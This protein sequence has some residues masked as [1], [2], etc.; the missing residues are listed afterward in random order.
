MSDDFSEKQCPPEDCVPAEPD[1][2]YANIMDH[3]GRPAGGYVHDVGLYITWQNGPLAVDGERKRPNGAFVET[4]IKAAKQRLEFYQRSP[5]A[6][7]ENASAIG[8]LNHAVA[9]L[10]SRTARRA[11]EGVEGTWNVDAAKEA[12]K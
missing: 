5:F 10:N 2:S 1:P 12:A 3:E 9:V 11:A 4:V 8:L 7:D 6:C